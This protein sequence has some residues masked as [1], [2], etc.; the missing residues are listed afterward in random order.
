MSQVST[1]KG[2]FQEG[3]E[4]EGRRDGALPPAGEPAGLPAAGRVGPQADRAA[5]RPP[6]RG[7][8]GGPT[9]AGR[10][11]AHTAVLRPMGERSRPPRLPKGI[12][13]GANGGPAVRTSRAIRLARREARFAWR[14]PVTPQ[15][16]GGR[17]QRGPV[18]RRDRQSR[19]GRFTPVGR[20]GG[21]LRSPPGGE[22]GDMN[23]PVRGAGGL[24]LSGC[25]CRPQRGRHPPRASERARERGGGGHASTRREGPPP[26]ENNDKQAGQPATNGGVLARR[27]PQGPTQQ[28]AVWYTPGKKARERSDGRAGAGAWLLQAS[29][30]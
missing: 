18:L 15:A 21:R 2:R 30:S 12:S 6:R 22:H 10:C 5:R 23:P 26:P 3:K 16:S 13:P 1:G 28:V 7:G 11:T 29:T 20:R 9:C 4:V 27:P 8:R 17:G 19:Q 25:G 14:P 24:P